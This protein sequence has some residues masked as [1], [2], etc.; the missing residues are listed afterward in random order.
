MN[1]VTLLVSGADRTE[2]DTV[3]CV[4]QISRTLSYPIRHLQ[5]EQ[6]ILMSCLFETFFKDSVCEVS[7][8]PD[9]C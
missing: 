6:I 2:L 7:A 4:I 9:K 8:H 3:N 1:R 5:A